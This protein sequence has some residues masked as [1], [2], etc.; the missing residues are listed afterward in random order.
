MKHLVLD[1]HDAPD[2]PEEA[3]SAMEAK[4]RTFLTE[5]PGDWRVEATQSAWKGEQNDEVFD[6][7]VGISLREVTPGRAQWILAWKADPAVSQASGINAILGTVLAMTVAVSLANWGMGLGGWTLLVGP[8]VGWMAWK[9]SVWWVHR[10]LPDANAQMGTLE[11]RVRERLS[12]LGDL[13]IREGHSAA[14]AL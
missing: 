12:T 5:L 13:T 6:L 2:T 4:F 11:E 8:A 9:T 10:H 1:Q 3:F 14:Q 7:Q